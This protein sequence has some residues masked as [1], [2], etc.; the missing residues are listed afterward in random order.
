[1]KRFLY[2]CMALVFLSCMLGNALCAL[3]P[4]AMAE[5]ASAQEASW[6][7]SVEET[8]TEESPE[9][10][11]EKY[12]EAKAM[13][14]VG[15]YEN[16]GY[17][18]AEVM[19]YVPYEDCWAYWSYARGALALS[20]GR[21]EEAF[22]CF[23]EEMPEY[24]PDVAKYKA[25]A[26]VRYQ[27]DQWGLSAFSLLC[28]YSQLGSFLDA[29]ERAEAQKKEIYDV[30]VEYMEKGE[31][32]DT[33]ADAFELLGDYLDA[34]QK[35]AAARSLFQQSQYEEAIAYESFERYELALAMFSSLEGYEDSAERARLLIPKAMRSYNENGFQYAIWGKYP[36]E[37]VTKP[38]DIYWRV[39]NVFPDDDIPCILLQ[40]EYILDARPMSKQATTAW[41]GTD[42]YAFLNDTS[43]QGFIGRAF[44]AEEQQLLVDR[45]LGRVYIFSSEVMM[46]KGSGYDISANRLTAATAFASSVGVTIN[47]YWTRSYYDDGGI[48][49]TVNQNGDVNISRSSTGAPI[50]AVQGLR[51]T[52]AVSL[53]A[54]SRGT[55]SWSDPFRME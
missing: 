16:A 6:E 23:S 27:E 39:I 34:P 47:S 13:L 18:F 11:I 53:D 52:C 42:L 22:E 43:P 45:G 5:D 3:A 54:F 37:S 15:D 25:Y 4:Q 49:D 2:F 51:V 9:S 44:T 40:S 30:A 41:I 29:A 26:S 46:Q 28:E 48:W 20:E 17:L 21:I 7:Q 35:A 24:F 31:Q 32:L 12:E 33:V 19:D 36:Q 8:P 55:G 14:L 38:S 1:M 10:Y 50:N